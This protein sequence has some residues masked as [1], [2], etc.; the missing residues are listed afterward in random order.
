M[1][2]AWSSPKLLSFDIEFNN[3]YEQIVKK[4][5]EESYLDLKPYH[6]K[7]KVTIRKKGW[8]R[9]GQNEVQSIPTFTNNRKA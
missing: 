4:R 1:F 2:P 3:T 5:S 9:S 6:R 8:G 7:T